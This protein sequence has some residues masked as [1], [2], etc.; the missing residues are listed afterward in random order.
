MDAKR[1]A[2]IIM[3]VIGFILLLFPVWQRLYMVIM[4]PPPSY[5]EYSPRFAAA[6]ASMLL[7][8]ILGVI[9]VGIT[10]LLLKRSTVFGALFISSGLLNFYLLTKTF[11]FC[12]LF[13]LL[14]YAPS[15]VAILVGVS[16]I[17]LPKMLVAHQNIE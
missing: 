9:F 7:P 5:Y 12:S 14:L 3:G 16:L 13:D 11:P 6:F 15:I 1:V 17:K 4:P 2:G 8:N 10:R